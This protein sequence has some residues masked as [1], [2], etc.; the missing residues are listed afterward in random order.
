MIASPGRVPHKRR[1]IL[2][3]TLMREQGQELRHQKRLTLEYIKQL[4]RDDV[5]R[6]DPTIV[7]PVYLHTFV[8]RDGYVPRTDFTKRV[9][10]ADTG[11]PP[12]A[13][14]VIKLPMR[15]HDGTSDKTGAAATEQAH[16]FR[17]APFRMWYLMATVEVDVYVAKH[18]PPAFAV[19][20]TA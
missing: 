2:K 9:T 4:T 8:D 12:L 6:F 5:N 11:L 1:E 3:Y 20:E 10:T 18:W 15:G 17:D 16:L 7:A 13:E 14:G 19:L